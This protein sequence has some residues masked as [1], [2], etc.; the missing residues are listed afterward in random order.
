MPKG[1]EVKEDEQDQAE[2]AL[3]SFRPETPGEHVD[4]DS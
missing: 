2:C 1:P 3:K 4:Q